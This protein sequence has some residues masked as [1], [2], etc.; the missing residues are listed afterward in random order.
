MFGF[1]KYIGRSYCTESIFRS[2]GQ[3]T[4]E[5]TEHKSIILSLIALP[6]PEGLPVDIWARF[7]HSCYNITLELKLSCIPLLRQTISLQDFQVRTDYTR[8]SQVV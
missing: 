3:Q 4:T 2:A 8:T 6:A 1:D 7:K 5:D